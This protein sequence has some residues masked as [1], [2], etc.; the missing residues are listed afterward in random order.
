MQERFLMSKKSETN[1][2]S[3]TAIVLG[4]LAFL[5]FPPFLGG[6]GV[7]L[8]VIG[9]SKNEKMWSIGLTV[10]IVGAIVGMIFGATMA[11]I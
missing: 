2:F 6:A 11:L 7:I 4:G 5:F 10:S 1:T 8:A 3:I 9:K